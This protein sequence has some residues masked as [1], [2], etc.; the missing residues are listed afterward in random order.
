MMIIGI[1]PGVNG[2][3]CACN[4]EKTYIAK[5][6][7]TPKDIY[8]YLE[9]LKQRDE[10]CVC[11]LE[12]V[13]H[14][15]PNQSSSATAKFARHNGHLEMALIALRIRTIKVTP[16]K[17][18]RAYSNTIGKSTGV[19]KNEWKNKLKALAQDLF[20][21]EK[22]TLGNADALLIMEYGKRNQ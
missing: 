10:D 6:P 21:D 14:G 1:D 12:D 17:W 16:Q 22:V 15:L 9:E 18:Q 13:G 11:Y 7:V 4:G 3:I 2:A 19:P 5:M 20:P 8:M